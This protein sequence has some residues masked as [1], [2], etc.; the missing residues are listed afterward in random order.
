M[1]DFAETAPQATAA[2]RPIPG[3][4]LDSLAVVLDLVRRSRAHSRSEIAAR[5]GLSRAVVAQRVNELLSRGLLAEADAPSTGG[6]PPRRLQFVADSGY[7]LVAD[8]GATHVDVAVSNLAGEIRGHYGEPADIAAGPDAVL[9]RVE[10]L[11]AIVSRTAQPRGCVWGI[12]IGVPGP[13][14]FSTGRPVLPPIMPGWDGYPIRERFANRFGVPVWV[15]NDVNAMA[16]GEWRAGIAQWYT[17]VIFI[18]VGTGIGAGIIGDGTIHR[19]AQGCAGDVGH[20]QV[21]NDRAVVCRCGY[22]GCLEAVAG[23]A[24][25]ARQGEELG[26]SGESAQLAAVLEEKGAITAEDVGR[27]AGFGDAACV[28]LLQR[29]GRLV[30]QMLAGLVN[31]FNPS[32]VVIGGG[33]A[34]SG[35]QYLA[36]IRETVYG[37]SLPLATRDLQVQLSSLG[38]AAGV[39]GAAAMVLDQLFS[40]RHLG[41][42]IESARPVEASLRLLVG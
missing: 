24:A 19:G 34:N 16:L 39:T 13:V 23:G 29:S 21:S 40:R 17:N 26:R 7:L 42:W 15:D 20:I 37:R 35:V 22:I 14:Q 5:A 1:P 31:F 28:E 41:S 3:E 11:F 18:K 27:A 25:I 2:S 9:D 4:A 6:R 12:G 8:L 36:S 33:V 38:A 10:E 32:L 30:G